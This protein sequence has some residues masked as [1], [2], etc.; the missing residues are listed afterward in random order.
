MLKT[1]THLPKSLWYLVIFTWFF[2]FYETQSLCWFLSGSFRMF[3]IF[4]LSD[5]KAVN[6]WYFLGKGPIYWLKVLSQQLFN[7]HVLS[8]QPSHLVSIS[9]VL[10]TDYPGGN[11]HS[12]CWPQ[13]FILLCDTLEKLLLNSTSGFCVFP[14]KFLSLTLY[15]GKFPTRRK[16]KVDQSNITIDPLTSFHNFQYLA[17]W[18]SIYHTQQRVSVLYHVISPTK[19]TAWLYNSLGLERNITCHHHL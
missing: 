14:I 8:K 19:S 5:T 15:Y 3:F 2:S 7:V 18:V 10:G 4:V 1:L 13:S 11:L 17:I 6:F 9:P 12:V 16:K